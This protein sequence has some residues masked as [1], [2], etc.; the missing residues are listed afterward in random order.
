MYCSE[1]KFSAVMHSR[2]KKN[3][4]PLIGH[5]TLVIFHTHTHTHTAVGNINLHSVKNKF[6]PTR[7]QTQTVQ[8]YVQ[9][10]AF[11]TYNLKT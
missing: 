10:P 1:M 5:F 4:W 8:N 11:L 2:S 7:W 9:C 3:S 6:K